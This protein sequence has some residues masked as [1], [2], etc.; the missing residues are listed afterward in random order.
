MGITP[1]QHIPSGK[2]DDEYDSLHARNKTLETEK[3]ALA[4]ALEKLCFLKRLK[5]QDGK[6]QRYLEEQPAAWEAARQILGTLEG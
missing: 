6:T 4:Q 1:S 2:I 3:A 5:D